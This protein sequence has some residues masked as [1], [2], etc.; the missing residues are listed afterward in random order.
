[1]APRILVVDAD[2][3]TRKR[4]RSLAEPL[5]IEVEEA[6]TMD[7]LVDRVRS[8]RADLVLIDLEDDADAGFAAV[9]RLKSEPETSGVQ[10]LALS[11]RLDSHRTAGATE[12]GFEDF[13]SKPVQEQE[14]VP[15]LRFHLDLPHGLN[16]A[17]P[18]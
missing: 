13:L 12:Q 14:L 15:I 9:N 5:G 16:D 2:A 8:A 18:L 6:D 11:T 10:V 3:T 17:H 7:G 4:I 1:M